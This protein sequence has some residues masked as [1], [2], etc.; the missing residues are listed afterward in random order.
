M[1]TSDESTGIRVLLAQRDPGFANPRERRVAA[2]EKALV[3]REAVDQ[4][5]LKVVRWPP[6]RGSGGRPG[7]HPAKRRGLRTRLGNVAARVLIDRHEPKMWLRGRTVPIAGINVGLIVSM[8]ASPAVTAARRLAEAGIPYVVDQG[9]PWGIGAEPFRGRGLAA[10]RRQ[11]IELRMW[12]GAAGGVFTTQSQADA[13]LNLVPDLPYLIRINGYRDFDRSSFVAAFE[14]RKPPSGELRLAHFGSLKVGDLTRPRLDPHSALASLVA[15][16]IWERVSLTQFGRAP[17]GPVWRE[18]GGPVS[19]EVVEPVPWGRAIEVASRFD[20]AI[21]VGNRPPHR[22]Q[23][24]SKVIEYLSLPIPRIALSSGA[25]GDELLSVS[26]S[27]PGYLTV[28]A[29]DPDFP[30][31]VDAF[32]RR[33]WSVDALVPPDEYSSHRVASDV[34]DFFLGATGISGPKP[35]RAG[36]ERGA[37]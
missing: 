21:V 25:Q 7:G 9:D 10:R 35:S 33:D 26:G 22:A 29:N 11:A 4:R 6:V 27:L 1:S 31:R 28:S 14:S 16:G 3:E 8:P 17:V 2:L 13:V 34:A 12:E 32:L 5:R 30:E 15:S 24:P 19:I 37:R 18:D 36:G 20:A 23:V